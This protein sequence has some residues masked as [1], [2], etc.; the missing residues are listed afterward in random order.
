MIRLNGWLRRLS[1]PLLWGA[2]VLIA[3]AMVL[4]RTAL[5]EGAA[6]GCYLAAFVLSGVPVLL[7]AVQALRLRTVSIELLVTIAAVGACAIGEFN[8]SA[9]VT[10]LFQL[11]S[12][13]E[14][15]TV[16]KTRSAIKAL[17]EL[18]PSTACRIT[19]TLPVASNV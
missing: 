5:P 13:L 4:S 15:K 19:P 1:L 11:G 10:F 7:R 8:E 2:G 17:T 16:K 9:I 12:F 6:A 3:L 18:A 14:Q